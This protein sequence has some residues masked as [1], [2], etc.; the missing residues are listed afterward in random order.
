MRVVKPLVFVCWGNL[1]LAPEVR[2]RNT[3]PHYLGTWNRLP[4]RLYVLCYYHRPFPLC[5]AREEIGRGAKGRNDER[6][7]LTL[8]LSTSRRWHGKTSRENQLGNAARCVWIR[9]VVC[10]LLDCIEIQLYYLGSPFANCLY[11][12]SFMA[13][14]LGCPWGQRPIKKY[15]LSMSTNDKMADETPRRLSVS[16]SP[17]NGAV[18][19][20][21]ERGRV[22]SGRL[23]N[24]LGSRFG[25]YTQIIA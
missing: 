4:T 17:F 5:L 13:F 12:H 2:S 15:L 22:I 16:H 11:S 6:L 10:L 19:F 21:A 8:L 24:R 23:A 9:S 20:F 7:S 3:F 1:T 25:T 18:F 14:L